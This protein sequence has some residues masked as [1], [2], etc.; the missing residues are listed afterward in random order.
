MDPL[1]ADLYT[2]I[3][4]VASGMFDRRDCGK[5]SAGSFRHQFTFSLKLAICSL[6]FGND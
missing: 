3:A 2:L 5:M 4:F 6:N 1:G